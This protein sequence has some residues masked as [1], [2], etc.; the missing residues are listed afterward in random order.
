MRNLAQ[1]PITVD[2][3]IQS[4]EE[5][6]SDDRSFDDDEDIAPFLLDKVAEFLRYDRAHLE[7]YLAAKVNPSKGEV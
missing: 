7:L 5:H 2:E 4:V 1:Y 3:L 6:A